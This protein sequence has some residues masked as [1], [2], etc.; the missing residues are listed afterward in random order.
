[1]RFFHQNEALEPSTCQ[2]EETKDKYFWNH[3]CMKEFGTIT[4]YLGYI[5]YYLGQRRRVHIP[6]LLTA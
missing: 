5:N 6:G 1:M 2:L 4:Q 3:R